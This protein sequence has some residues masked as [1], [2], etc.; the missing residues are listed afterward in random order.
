MNGKRLL[1]DKITSKCKA[2]SENESKYN[3]S[4]KCKMVGLVGFEPTTFTRSKACF[5][6]CLA[7]TGF[8]KAPE[9]LHPAMGQQTRHLPSGARRHAVPAAAAWAGCC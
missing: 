3:V 7:P 8:F 2:F 4:S 6:V 1:E 5:H 9:L